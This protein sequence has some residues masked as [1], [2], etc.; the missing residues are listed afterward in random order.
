[1]AHSRFFYKGFYLIFN[2]FGV[3]TGEEAFSVL[4]KVFPEFFPVNLIVVL[5]HWYRARTDVKIQTYSHMV[6]LEIF[7]SAGA[8]RDV[9]E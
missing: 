8:V 9:L 3:V 1:M 2:V 4:S 7:Y 5:G 6:R